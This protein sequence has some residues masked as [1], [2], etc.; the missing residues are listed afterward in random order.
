MFAV[1]ALFVFQ[2]APTDSIVTELCRLL[3]ICN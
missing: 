1:L 3:R 2:I